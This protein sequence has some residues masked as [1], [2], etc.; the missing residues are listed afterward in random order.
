MRH[1]LESWERQKH[2][3]TKAMNEA[4]A[5]LKVRARSVST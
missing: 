5:A 4:F 3:E 2:A 1:C